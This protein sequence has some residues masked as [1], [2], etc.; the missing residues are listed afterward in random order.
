MNTT[1][2]QAALAIKRAMYANKHWHIGTH[3]DG[4][5]AL[6]IDRLY[7]ELADGLMAGW[8][9]LKAVDACNFGEWS[10]AMEQVITQERNKQQQ[11]DRFDY[12]N[13]YDR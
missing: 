9:G 7:G 5:P 13:K 3:D 11:V 1:V 4:T 2:N 12:T 8:E 6:D 10:A